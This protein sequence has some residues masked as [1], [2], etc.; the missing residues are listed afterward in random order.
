VKLDPKQLIVEVEKGLETEAQGRMDRAKR[1]ID[2]WRHDGEQ[3]MQ[4]FL[5]PAETAWDY[6]QRPYR[7]SGLTAEIVGV[8]TQH[9]YAPGPSRTWSEPAGQEFLE[10]VYSDNHLDALMLRCDELATLGDAAALQV[11]VDEGDFAKKPVTLRV[12]GPDEFHVWE[13][14]DNRNQPA[15]VVTKDK[16]DQQTRYRLWTDEECY[17]FLTKKGEGTSGGRVATLVG[18]EPN[19]YQ[20]LPF[21]FVH[22]NYPAQTFWECGPGDFIARSEIRANDRLSRLDEAVQR[23]LDPHLLV[24]NARPGWR[25]VA[26][27]GQPVLL[28]S[29]GVIQG[30]DGPEPGP[31]VELEYLQG[32]PDIAVAWEDLRGGILQVLEAM[33]VPESAIRQVQ[34]SVA[35][36]IALLVEQA[37]LL[38]RARGR[39][40]AFGVYEG[41]LARTVLRCAGNHYRRAELVTAA[42]KGILSLGWPAPSIPVPTDDWLQTEVAK[43]QAGLKSLI[44]V[45]QEMYGVAREQAVEILRQVKADQDELQT[46]MPDLSGTGRPESDE[47]T[48]RPGEGDTPEPDDR[49]PKGEPE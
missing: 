1:A 32:H 28:P 7:D 42:A 27:P 16:Y 15:A 10:R 12:W 22:Y 40:S 8:L 13:D 23:Y 4:E 48:E 20:C 41:E 39:R 43:V 44:M 26:K 47:E 2:F 21:G 46:I 14:P 49:P 34:A 24:K 37:P 36:G 5:R 45:A 35:S 31:P 3:H 29:G 6:A 17:T 33:G 30:P 25:L 9:L 19:T 11:D 38:T 18:T